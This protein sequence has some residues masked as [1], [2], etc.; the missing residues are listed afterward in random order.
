MMPTLQPR[1]WA[2]AGSSSPT[3]GPLSGKQFGLV[4]RG[5]SEAP[6]S[7]KVG[8]EIGKWGGGRGALLGGPE[9]GRDAGSQR[10]PCWPGL[11]TWSQSCLPSLPGKAPAPLISEQQPLPDSSQSLFN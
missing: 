5:K 3:P 8:R 1:H 2:P 7:G 6:G 11:L 10:C 4:G 9:G